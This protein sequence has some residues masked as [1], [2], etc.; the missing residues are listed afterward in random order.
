SGSARAGTIR[1]PDVSI[2]IDEDPMRCDQQS[3]TEA[4]DQFSMFV[5]VKDRIEHRV[6]AGVRAAAL[7][8]PNRFAVLVY[9]NGAGGSPRSSFGQLRPTRECLVRVGL[10]VRRLGIALGESYLYIKRNTKT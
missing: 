8:N 10:G 5:E 3:R 1:D 4:L 7:G 6:L 9:F 2:A